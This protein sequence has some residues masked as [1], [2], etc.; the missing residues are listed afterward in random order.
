MFESTASVTPNTTISG[1]AFS[2]RQ[3][4]SR[5]LSRLGAK[6]KPRSPKTRG[7]STLS[8]HGR[9]V[10]ALLQHQLLQSPQW[11]TIVRSARMRH[12]SSRPFPASTRSPLRRDAQ[13]GIGRCRRTMN[14][15]GLT[16]RFVPMHQNQL[17]HTHAI[18]PADPRPGELGFTLV[19]LLVVIGIIA[20]LISVLLP[21]LSRARENA[22]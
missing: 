21:S 10:H 16:R 22:N 5:A 11:Y 7:R 1:I 17:E 2:R 19:E 8:S 14:K 4:T 12:A 18:P 20:I 6:A 15:L 13:P 3:S 9:L